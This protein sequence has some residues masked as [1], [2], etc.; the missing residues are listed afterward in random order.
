MP[1]VTEI[2]PM[3]FAGLSFILVSQI[4]LYTISNTILNAQIVEIEEPTG[5]FT[6]GTVA[7]IDLDEPLPPNGTVIVDI[8]GIDDINVDGVPPLGMT[9]LVQN[10]TITLTDQ[11]VVISN[12]VASRE[13]TDNDDGEQ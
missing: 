9:I 12:D 8:M 1:R 3:I 13:E 7:K 2:Y 11:N 6:E 10:D 5:N 4:W